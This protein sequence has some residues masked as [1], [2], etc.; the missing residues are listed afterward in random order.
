MKKYEF[1]P[2]NKKYAELFKKEK[3]RILG[4]C[5]GITLIE[6]VGSTAV[7]GLGGKGI[8]DIAIA[9]PKETI[10]NVSQSL[11]DLGYEFRSVWSTLERLYFIIYLE[12]SNSKEPQ[13]YHIHLMT[14]ESCELK[15]MISFR[16]YLLSHPE[17]MHLYAELK[18][19]A[20][21]EAKGDGV[22]Y[23]A[24]KLPLIKDMLKKI[25]EKG[26]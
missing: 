16:N 17:E 18:R 5:E 20:A 2:Y 24:Y 26:M 15:E 19:K 7:P 25:R 4:H 21:E 8:I 11:Q 10:E 6:H 22:K 12:D 9:S 3:D 14:P 13:R 1:K 23:R